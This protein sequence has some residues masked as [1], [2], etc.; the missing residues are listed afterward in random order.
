MLSAASAALAPSPS[1][2][3]REMAAAIRGTDVAA[4]QW[5][6]EG[7]SPGDAQAYVAAGCFDVA[8]TAQLRR[9]GISALQMARSGLGWD[10]SSGSL[11]LAELRRLM[12]GADDAGL[13]LLPAQV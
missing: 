11:S 2:L 3:L 13:A 4:R 6:D 12:N 1:T 7:F 10:Y 8:R 9:A 5:M